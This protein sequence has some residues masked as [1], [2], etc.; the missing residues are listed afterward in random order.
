MSATAREIASARHR[1][2]PVVL[3][4]L[5]LAMGF[6]WLPLGRWIDE[7]ADTTHLVA[8]EAAWWT[9]VAALLCYVRKVEQRPLASIGLGRPG[10]RSLALGLA[11]GVAVTGVLGALYMLVLPALHLDDKVAD[12]ANAHLL[13]ATPLWWRLISTVRAGVSEEVMFR[14]YAMERLQELSGSRAFAVLISCA[15]FTLAHVG[16]WGWS[17]EIVVAAG[18]LMFSLLY[19]WRRN[20]WINMTAHFVVDAISV[21]G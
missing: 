13:S 21:L 7:F 16:A 18:G 11:S 17:H 4:G 15:V 9:A 19:L 14:G 6:A 1:N 10:L 5:L 3:P 12:T 2:L 8:Y 20:L